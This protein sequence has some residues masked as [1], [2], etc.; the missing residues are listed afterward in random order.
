M[1]RAVIGGLV[2]GLVMFIWGAVA[3]MALPLGKVG[4]SEIPGEQAV[5]E[6]MRQSISEPGVYLFPG[7]DMSREQSQE[8]MTAWVERYR[9]GPTGLLVYQPAGEQ[10]LSPAKFVRQ[11]LADVAAAL[12]AATIL[13]MVVARSFWSRVLV[14]GMMGL[15]A[16][17]S[18]SIPYW[19]WYRFP[20]DFTMAAAAQQIVGWLLA[21]AAMAAI[22]R[23]RR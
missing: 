6:T 22:I 7:M 21:G 5:V 2:G 16:W 1:N 18:I 14:V 9:R 17:L 20:S 3:N 11:L 8:E 10:P 19:N 13:S 15:F 23:P 12:I 4:I